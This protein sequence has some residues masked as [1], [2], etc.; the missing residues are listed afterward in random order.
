MATEKPNR[1]RSL[2]EGGQARALEGFNCARKRRANRKKEESTT[3]RKQAQ[4]TTKDEGRRERWRALTVPGSAAPTDNKKPTKDERGHHH[5][6]EK[7]IARKMAARS[8]RAQGEEG[9]KGSGKGGGRQGRP[10]CPMR[11]EGDRRGDRRQRGAAAPKPRPE[12]ATWKKEGE[13]RAE[14]EGR[15]ARELT[16]KQQEAHH[17]KLT[18]WRHADGG[19]TDAFCRN[20]TGGK[21]RGDKP[22]SRPKVAGDRASRRGRARYSSPNIAQCSPT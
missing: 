6:Q 11:T 10:L 5:H 3:E 12:G 16:K 14:R 7:V 20:R 15:A 9:E 22:N 19:T 13:R 18:S 2:I 8:L 17:A 21:G 1:H 4:K